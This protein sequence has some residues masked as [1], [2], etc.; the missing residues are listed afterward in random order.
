[1]KHCQLKKTLDPID[2]SSARRKKVVIMDA[3]YGIS[4]NWLTPYN[5]Y[6]RNWRSATTIYR[7][8]VPRDK[9]TADSE[10]FETLIAACY[11]AV[12]SCDCKLT[13]QY[14]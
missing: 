2:Q 7:I 6:Y 13:H 10:D 1:M 3:N 8:L 9:S 12:C 14:R 4:L 5:T 11:K